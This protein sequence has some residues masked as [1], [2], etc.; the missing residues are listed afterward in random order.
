M[1]IIKWVITIY[2]MMGFVTLRFY[3]VDFRDSKMDISKFTVCLIALFLF[4]LFWFLRKLIAA[5]FKL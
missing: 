2:M 4:P 1:E 5:N 3:L